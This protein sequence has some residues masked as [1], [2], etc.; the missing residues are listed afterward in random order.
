MSCGGSPFSLLPVTD[1]V[2]TLK[3]LA[4][5]PDAP[6]PS[7]TQEAFSQLTSLQGPFGERILASA[8]RYVVT[9]QPWIDELLGRIRFVA[10]ADTFLTLTSSMPEVR[11]RVITAEP[12]LLDSDALLDIKQPDLSE[13]LSLIPEESSVVRNVVARLVRLDDRIVASQVYHRFPGEAIDAI[14][15]ALKMGQTSET[16]S[17]GAAWM[18]LP[19]VLRKRFL[20]GGFVEA[21]LSLPLLVSYAKLLGFASPEVLEVGPLPWV[22]A[23]KSAKTEMKTPHKERFLAFL[24]VLALGSSSI[25]VEPLLE[26]AFDPIY[27]DLANSRLPEEATSLLLPHLPDVYW[28]DRWDLCLR[29]RMAVV[30][31]YVE[32][33][34]DPTSFRRVTQDQGVF[35]VMV[36]FAKKTGQGRRYVRQMTLKAT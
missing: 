11:R 35:E 31:A 5:H 20:G 32:R 8:E 23:I 28:W 30:S 25:G 13:L 24:L 4:D 6:L 26:F 12:S 10:E 2:D 33:D 27:E 15:A 34:L 36:D 22:A 19:A 18:P 3:F 16:Y 14:A 29:L 21:A 7:P 1:L 17:I 9:G